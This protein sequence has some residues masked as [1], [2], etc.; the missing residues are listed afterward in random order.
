[1][2]HFVPAVNQPHIY[3]T[4]AQEK[5]EAL[6]KQFAS[7]EKE[8]H[9]VFDRPQ[10]PI[11]DFTEK[12]EDTAISNMD[13]L[14][15]QQKQLR[16]QEFRQYAPPGPGSVSPNPPLRIEE[17]PVNIRTDI[18]EQYTEVQEKKK[19]TFGDELRVY[20]EVLQLHAN[21]ITDMKG[22]LVSLSELIGT[23]AKDIQYIKQHINSAR[24]TS[25][26]DVSEAV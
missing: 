1:L 16:E 17:T 2:N 26:V 12:I 4:S 20:D 18:I 8:Y 22:I 14:I 10:P 19:V 11:P 9:S 23:L 13:E 3:K 6:D 21:E 5:Q 7:R 25:G 15:R 24:T